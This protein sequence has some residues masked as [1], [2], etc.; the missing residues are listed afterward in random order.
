MQIV[1]EISSQVP[2]F[3]LFLNPPPFA[4]LFDNIIPIKY[5]INTKIS[6]CDIVISSIL[7][8]YKTM[9]HAFLYKN[10]LSNTRLIF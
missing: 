10:T 7:E 6:S 9:L 1:I 3:Y 8:D 4:R 2:P 5:W